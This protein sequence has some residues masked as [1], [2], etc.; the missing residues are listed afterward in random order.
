VRL[1]LDEH[2][3]V[4]LARALEGHQADTVVSRGWA[5]LKNGELLQRMRGLYDA[6]ITMDRSLEFQQNIAA[7]PFGVLVV[8]AA[9]NRLP[10]LLP[11][12]P[13]ILTAVPSIKPGQVHRIGR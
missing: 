12:V 2:L 8:R 1:L 7:L 9:S 6:L 4:D 5:G 13:L 10:D 11:L 3:P